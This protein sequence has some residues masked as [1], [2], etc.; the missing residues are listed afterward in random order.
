VESRVN[1]L[2]EKPK[3]LQSSTKQRAGAIKANGIKE[4]AEIIEEVD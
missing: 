2:H 3:C 1:G 4:V